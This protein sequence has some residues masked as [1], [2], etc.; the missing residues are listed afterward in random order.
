[1]LV[2]DEATSALDTASER[3]VQSALATLMLGRTT[4]AIAHRLSTI[5]SAD[6]IHVVDRGR[7]IESG[8]HAELVDAGGLYAR[9]YQ[10]QFEGGRV[11]ARCADGVVYSDGTCQFHGSLSMSA[12]R[13]LS[14]HRLPARRG[15]G[16]AEPPRSPVPARA[17]SWPTSAA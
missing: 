11:E 7:I 9:L 10:E 12:R 2:L 17:C 3:Q 1:V 4:L 15:G 13:K 14:A 16:A 8:G 5:R 6:V